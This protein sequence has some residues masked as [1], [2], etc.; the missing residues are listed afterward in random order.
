MNRLL[1]ADSFNN[2]DMFYATNILVPDPFIFVSTNYK[3]YIITNS[4]EYDRIKKDTK[5]RIKVINLN[6]YKDKSKAKFKHINL[7]TIAYL[8]L[9]EKGINSVYVS[10]DF[11]LNYA[12]FLRE[13]KINIKIKDRIFDRSIK[14]P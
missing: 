10:N 9:K 4:L 8:F 7:A 14:T 5:G 12:D 13:N 2:S 1:I 11:P 6:K 3:D